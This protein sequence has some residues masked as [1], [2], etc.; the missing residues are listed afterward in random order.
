MI[1]F[2]ELS[3]MVFFTQIIQHFVSL[4]VIKAISIEELEKSTISFV[5]D[6]LILCLFQ[7]T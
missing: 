7:T 3:D 1:T 5:R 4:K 2:S 6:F